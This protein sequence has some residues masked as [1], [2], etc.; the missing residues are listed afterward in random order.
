[1]LN[2]PKTTLGGVVVVAALAM[3]WTRALTT[4]QAVT[5]LGLAG[6]WIGV[7]ARDGGA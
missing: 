5:L 3:L 6:A 7:A 4:E 2:N 1:M